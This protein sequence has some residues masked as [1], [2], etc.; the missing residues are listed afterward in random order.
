MQDLAVDYHLL[1]G[2]LQ[3]HDDLEVVSGETD[4]DKVLVVMRHSDVD[5]RA[6]VWDDKTSQLHVGTYLPD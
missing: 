1:S 2:P 3:D 4:D 5:D 6:T